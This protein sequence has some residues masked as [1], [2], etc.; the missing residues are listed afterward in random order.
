MKRY[1]SI[2]GWFGYELY[3]QMSIH[4][5]VWLVTA[6]LGYGIFNDIFKDYPHQSLNCGASEVAGMDVCVG[7]ALSGK[8]PFF[9]SI[10]PF[11]VYRP[12]EVLRTYI[13]HEKIPVVI[14][15]SGIDRDYNCDGFTHH[16]DDIY[17]LKEMFKNID[18]QFPNKKEQIPTM[19]EDVINKPRPM[20]IGLRR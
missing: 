11:A 19:I 1:N 16:A 4:H 9:Y 20:F 13:N 12:F 6:D 14:C 5:K 3:H 10:T 17:P 15:G 2:R 8:L 7:L 18:W